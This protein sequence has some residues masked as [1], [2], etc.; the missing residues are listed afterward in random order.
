VNN[1][2]IGLLAL[3]AAAWPLA[4]ATNSG[5]IQTTNAVA[6]RTARV[7]RAKPDPKDPVEIEYQ[8]IVDDDD[9]A[10]AQ[11]DKWIR[12]NDQFAAQGSGIPPPEMKRRIQERFHPIQLAY[13]KFLKEHPDH[14]R[15]HMAYGSF[16]GD[17]QDEDGAQEHWE[18]ALALD[19]ADP[20]AYNNLANVYGHRGPVKK[21]F[22]YYSKAIELNT[23]EPVYYH[24]FATTVYLFRKDAKEY[25]GISEQEVFDKTIELDGHA[26]KLDPTNFPLASDVAQTYYNIRPLRINEALKAW[27]NTL[28]IANDEV[29][30]EGVYIHFARWNLIG[31]RFDAARGQISRV[32]NEMYA[33]LKQ[34]I[35]RNINKQ[36][37]EAKET[38]APPAEAS[39]TNAS[40]PSGSVPAT[41]PPT[42]GAPKR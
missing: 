17:M 31:G 28:A 29:E 36:E 12:D 42:A 1:A 7:T 6:P 16:L 19:P 10:Q 24:N 9:A 14:A 33:D 26:L 39:A 38:N 21:A 35:V 30:R 18:K 3:A 13:E 27:T 41:N 23:N 32:T 40:P 22:E 8:K 4:A 5:V 15:A 25:F 37:K 11:V 34:R 2:L 20:A